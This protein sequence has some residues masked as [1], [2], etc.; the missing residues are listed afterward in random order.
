MQRLG[1]RFGHVQFLAGRGG[2]QP[3]FERHDDNCGGMGD[4]HKPGG[5][6]ESVFLIGIRQRSRDEHERP[7]RA[8]QEKRGR[9]LSTVAHTEP[10][11]VRGLRKQVIQRFKLAG[12]LQRHDFRGHKI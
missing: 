1:R 9:H 3:G 8:N 7:V 5:G 10:G 6:G 12:R 4:A 11:V 2:L